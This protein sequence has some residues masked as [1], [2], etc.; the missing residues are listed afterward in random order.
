MRLRYGVFF[1]LGLAISCGKTHSENELD[2][3]SDLETEGTTYYGEI[4]P[5]INQ[6]CN[7][8][9]TPGGVGP[10]VFDTYDLLSAQS[11]LV[12]SAIDSGA[13]PP[14]P[15]SPE[16]NTYRGQ[17][18]LSSEEKARFR[19]WIDDGMQRG[20]SELAQDLVAPAVLDLGPAE[21]VARPAGPY[22]PSVA[23]GD[24]YR[25]FLLDAEFQQDVFV[26][27]VD[28]DPGNDALVHHANLFLLNPNHIPLV[29]EL[30]N[31]TPEPGY[32][33]FGNAGVNTTNL[34]GSWVPGL[35]PIV[36]PDGHAVRIRAGSRI[37]MQTHFNT[38]YTGPAP[39]APAFNLYTYDGIPEHV[40]RAMP[41]ANL[42]IVIPAG[43]ARSEHVET[44]KN[45]SD[46]TWRVLGSAAHLHLLATSVKVDIQ[47]LGDEP[48]QCILDIPKWDF[49]WQMAYLFP[50]G[51]AVEVAP[52]DSV[53]LT[54]VFD[55]SPENQPVIDGIPR[56]PVDVRWGGGTFDEMC[57]N[58]L[59]VAEPFDPTQVGAGSLC[60]EFLTC[61]ETCEDPFS[62][63]C[64]FNCGALELDCGECLLGGAQRCASRFCGPELRS[65]LT[66]IYACAQGA[67][68]GGDIDECL[69]ERCPDE[70]NALNECMRPR[71]EGGF[72]NADLTACNVDF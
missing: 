5:W 17:R 26:R 64:I 6:H 67:Q 37:V 47:K 35:D 25:C 42:G 48:N 33:C 54:C 62:V 60:E 58:F 29:E 46:K 52:G 11:E 10:F 2:A 24:E 40:V 71:V 22:T 65:S 51:E 18:L 7:G 14:W 23:A 4:Q 45:L 53:R 21:I 55:N 15:A 38:I 32:P 56:T 49:N 63:G 59:I 27:A 8:C 61:R 34:V 1:C 28:V 31:A 13:M 19:S 41:F 43:E 66:C 57:M 44:F 12:W 16:C 30:E 36:L 9:H 39:V 50:D 20:S 3:G 70:R 72:C 69:V 68:A